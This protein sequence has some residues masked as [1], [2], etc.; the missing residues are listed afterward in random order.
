MLRADPSFNRL[1][2]GDQQRL[3]QQLH[4]VNQM[5]E[6][7]RARRL[8]RNEMLERLS[9]Q[10]RMQANQAMH[11]WAALPSERQTMMKRAFQDLRAVPLDQRETVLNS[12]RYQNAFSPQERGIL[13][14]LLR[15]EPYE[16]AR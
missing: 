8:E 3:L 1:P 13:S 12:A 7:Q 5:P 10:D 2:Q 4:Q 15:V 11:T 9:P 14:D 16:P 6:D